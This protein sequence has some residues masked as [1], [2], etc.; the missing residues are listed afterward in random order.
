MARTTVVRLTGEDLTTADV[1]EVAVEGAVAELDDSA[2]AK[3]RAAREVVDRAVAAEG[4][5]YGVTTGFGRFV[6]TRVPGELAEELQLR[7]LRSHACG[8]G[9]PYPD[10]IVR[11]ALLMRANTLAKGYSGTRPEV[12]QRLLDCLER[13]IL[14]EVPSRGSVGASGDLAPLAHL[15]LPLVGEGRARIDG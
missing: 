1:W 11:A 6:S 5:T 8:V 7:L 10:E 4:P 14:P 3:M 12:A 15:A 9:E 13:G 2:R